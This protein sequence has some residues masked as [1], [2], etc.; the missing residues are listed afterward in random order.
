MN[1]FLY[2]SS[3]LCAAVIIV[4][5]ESKGLIVPHDARCGLE[6]ERV[7]AGLMPAVFDQRH[8]KM[9]AEAPERHAAAPPEDCYGVSVL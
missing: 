5:R 9:T 8:S 4:A 1:P 6:G 7:G 2:L 3:L